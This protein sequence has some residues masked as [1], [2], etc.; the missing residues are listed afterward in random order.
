MPD[1][2]DWSEEVRLVMKD[3]RQITLRRN[4]DRIVQIDNGDG[5]YL[6]IG[7][8]SATNLLTWVEFF[9]SLGADPA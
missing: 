3:G 4:E 7:P 9:Q 1:A 8:I 2:P 5:E 6:D